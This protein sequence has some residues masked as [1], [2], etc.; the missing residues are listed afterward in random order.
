MNEDLNRVQ[1]DDVQTA[2]ESKD[3][4]VFE[5]Q[6]RKRSPGTHPC[7]HLCIHL[8]FLKVYLVSPSFYAVHVIVELIFGKFSTSQEN[9]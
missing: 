5:E 6:T 4:L 7:P 1:T 9:T 8:T 3:E 2:S